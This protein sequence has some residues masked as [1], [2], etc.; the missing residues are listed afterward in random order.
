MLRLPV[1]LQV[2]LF[3]GRV[4]TLITWPF[5]LSIFLRRG[6]MLGSDVC[7]QMALGRTYILTLHT[8]I[9]LR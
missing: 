8:G 9:Q 1:S 2:T 4:R 7:P 6:R 5:S 3:N